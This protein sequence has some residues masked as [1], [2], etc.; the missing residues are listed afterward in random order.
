MTRQTMKTLRIVMGLTVILGVAIA[1]VQLVDRTEGFGS[2]LS[3]FK[4]RYPAITS[5]RLDTCGVCHVDPSG[6]GPRNP[7]GQA[8]EKQLGAGKAIGDALAAI[9]PDDSDGDGVSNLAEIS[10][11][12]FPGDPNDKP[13]VATPTPAPTA[14]PTPAPTSA[15]TPLPNPTALPSPTLTPAPAPGGAATAS[16][17]PSPAP[18][19]PGGGAAV[20]PA[21]ITTPSPVLAATQETFDVKLGAPEGTQLSLSGGGLDRDLALSL[22]AGGV[23][24]LIALYA[25][26][27]QQFIT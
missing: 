25:L 13:A 1:F 22:G 19:S 26:W 20:S 15:P 8:A 12:T 24:A 10:A 14:A 23:L 18:P 9:E 21:P 5:T 4:T 2:Y 16:P 3:G 11:L 6:G 17:A 27:R 7:Y